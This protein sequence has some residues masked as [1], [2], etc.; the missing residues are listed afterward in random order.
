MKKLNLEIGKAALRILNGDKV[1][2]SNILKPCREPV[3][4]SQRWNV[5]LGLSQS[6]F[7]TDQIKTYFNVNPSGVQYALREL[8]KNT[9]R[10]PSEP[11]TDTLV[12]KLM[13][14]SESMSCALKCHVLHQKGYGL[15]TIG[16]Y[17]GITHDSVNIKLLRIQAK[18]EIKAIKSKQSNFYIF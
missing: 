18:D 9:T 12:D 7:S 5:Y 14:G 6:G 17:F 10:S 15:N 13:I 2:L 3:V 16:R 8:R 11:I 4:V 1:R